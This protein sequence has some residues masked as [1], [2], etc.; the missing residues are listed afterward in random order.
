[1]NV[2]GK[3]QP[4]GPLRCEREP[5]HT[6]LHVATDWGRKERF[7][8]P[9]S[10]D[11]KKSQPNRGKRLKPVGD[12][13]QI[14]TDVVTG[15][16]AERVWRRRQ[17]GA[18]WFPCECSKLGCSDG[19]QGA[20]VSCRRYGDLREP[21]TILDNWHPH[22]HPPRRT[23][24]KANRH[25]VFASRSAPERIFIVHPACHKRLTASDPEFSGGES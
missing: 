25:N 19:P 21:Q 14:D 20:L 13:Q 22:H 23:G 15:I 12:K 16:M 24:P 3:R 1:M 10:A 11:K 5:G 8:W 2:C 17:D 6:G 4:G 7:E 9:N 18:I